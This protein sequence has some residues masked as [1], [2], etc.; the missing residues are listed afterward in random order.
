MPDLVRNLSCMPRSCLTNAFLFL[1]SF[2][3][4]VN[5]AVKAAER[6]LFSFLNYD[7]L[8]QLMYFLTCRSLKALTGLQDFFSYKQSQVIS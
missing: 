8:L 4:A 5:L 1:F 7:L 6:K 2:G 3:L